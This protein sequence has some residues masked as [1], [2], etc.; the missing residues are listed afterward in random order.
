MYDFDSII[1]RTGTGSLKHDFKGKY[2]KGK[3]VLAMWV[4]DM[5]FRSPPCVEE[6]VI[7]RARHGIYGYTE[8]ED[9]YYDAVTKWFSSLHGWDVTK[10]EIVPAPGVIFAMA[11]AINTFTQPGDS[12]II[13]SPVY[14]H[15]RDIIEDNGRRTVENSLILGDDFRY[16]ID[17]D[18]F[19]KKIVSED[20]KMFLLCNPHNPGGRTWSADELSRLGDICN[21][22]DVL[23]VSDEIHADINLYKKHT[24][25]ASLGDEYAANSIICT[26]PSK[27][28]NLPGLQTAN[29]VIKDPEL[30]SLFKK[31]Y[32]RTGYSQLNPLGLSTCEAVY[33]EGDLWREEMLSHIR[34]N[35]EYAVSYI[36][37]RIPG[38]RA[39][40][41]D[42]TYLLWIDFRGL[43]LER[44]AIREL[45]EKD[46]RL[47]LNDG[48]SFGPEGSGF[49]RMNL[50]CPR[51]VVEEAMRRL[52][53]AV[54]EI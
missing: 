34:G 30:R 15:F 6:A 21:A 20:V 38:I 33:R 52:E 39:M 10:E 49:F 50:A 8:P 53:E 44:S 45:L 29:I 23:V 28:F 17:F 16:E 19:E 47:W 22:H 9:S 2:G 54:K 12:V 5:D 13:Q 40:V 7:A 41:P 32:D 27:V 35:V 25:Y 37:R 11:T 3:D 46:A 14:M 24:V 43:G 48:R 26:S 1:D 42:S 18:D 31:G 36:D 4:A 51:S